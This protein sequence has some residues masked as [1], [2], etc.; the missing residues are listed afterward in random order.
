[1]RR[2]H[3]HVGS[4]RMLL[5][6]AVLGAVTSTGAAQT[7]TAQDLLEAAETSAW[8][9]VFEADVTIASTENGEVVSQMRLD[10]AHSRDRGTYMEVTEPARSRGLRLLQIDDNLWMYNPRARSSRAVRLSPQASF[11]GS[12]FS[13]RDLSDPQFSD[14]YSVSIARTEVLRDDELGEVQCSVL[15]AE[16][17]DDTVAYARVLMWVRTSDGLLLRAEYYAKSG[18]LY[19][20]AEFSGIAELGGRDRPTEIRMISQQAQG[21]VSTMTIHTMRISDSLPARQFTQSYLTR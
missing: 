16:A 11:Q 15:E 13:N 21:T 18:L 10:V 5:V 14:D 19:K 7:P 20:R 9:R 3:S 6:V 4:R 8:P 1:M 2:P 12:V 17:T